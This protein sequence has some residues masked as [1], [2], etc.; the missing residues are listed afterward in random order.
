M[1]SRCA[2]VA[3]LAACLAFASAYEHQNSN[4]VAS[5]VASRNYKRVPPPR[6]LPLAPSQPRTRSAARWQV[7]VDADGVGD[8]RELSVRGQTAA[9]RPE[10]GPVRGLPVRSRRLVAVAP[11]LS[12]L[13]WSWTAT[14]PHK[15][16]LTGPSASL[17]VQQSDPGVE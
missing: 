1:V 5:A 9:V 15:K 8:P 7:P 4:Q 14:R 2:I 16:K 13:S 10:R 3:C 12:L 17:K 11:P 6:A